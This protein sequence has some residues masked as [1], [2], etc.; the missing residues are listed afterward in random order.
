MDCPTTLKLQHS[1]PPLTVMMPDC[2]NNSVQWAS[3]Q[4]TPIDSDDGLLQQLCLY[5]LH[6]C[7]PPLTV[8]MPDCTT[9]Y[10]MGFSTVHPH[11]TVMMPDCSNNGLAL[12]T[13]IDSDDARLP[14]S[15][16]WASSQS[17]PIDSDDARLPTTL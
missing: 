13:P 17:T 7:P 16:V 2:S 5:G 6:H 15:T 1:P 4:S 10:C 9:L 14:T 11:C 8:M 3:A 12:S